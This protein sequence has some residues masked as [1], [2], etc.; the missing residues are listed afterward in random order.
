MSKRKAE[1][2]SLNNAYT[3]LYA[4]KGTKKDF[5]SYTFKNRLK[6]LQA[7]AYA[8]T[9]IKQIDFNYTENNGT[10]LPGLLSSPNFYGY[11]QGLGGPTLGVLL[12]SQA[13]IRRYAIANSWISSPTLMTGA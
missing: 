7:F 12:G 4:K 5:K 2:D 6:P 10:V 8:L 3:Q 1:I 11:G 13:D 9:S